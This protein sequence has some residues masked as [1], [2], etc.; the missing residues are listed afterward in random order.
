M[1]L[2][3]RALTHQ[4]RYPISSSNDH[5]NMILHCNPL[6]VQRSLVHTQHLRVTTN[7]AT[8][9]PLYYFQE[10]LVVLVRLK[11]ILLGPL[12]LRNSETL[13]D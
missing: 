5:P 1:T 8:F 4:D 6:S 3:S 7:S 11:S 12:R 9:I 10:S 13:V 2:S